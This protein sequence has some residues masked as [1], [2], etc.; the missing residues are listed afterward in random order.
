[1][2]NIIIGKRLLQSICVLQVFAAFN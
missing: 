2:I 1:M